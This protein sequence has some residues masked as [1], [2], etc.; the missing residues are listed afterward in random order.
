MEPIEH[1][2]GYHQCHGGNG[3]TYGTNTADDIN[4]VS[5]LLGEEIAT[6]YEKREIHYYA[7]ISN[8]YSKYLIFLTLQ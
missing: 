7:L 1:T 5:A 6:G 2:E 3:N 4:G 8:S